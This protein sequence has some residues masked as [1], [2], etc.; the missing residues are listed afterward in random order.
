[1]ERIAEQSTFPKMDTCDVSH[2]IKNGEK[3]VKNVKVPLCW[4]AS[5]WRSLLERFYHHQMYFP[6]PF[7]PLGGFPPTSG[8]AIAV[9]VRLPCSAV[10][11]PLLS[12]P[13]PL[14]PAPRPRASFV[15][16]GGFA[17]GL[18]GVT[19]GTLLPFCTLLGQHLNGS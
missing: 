4:R 7:L 16:G 18:A 17:M 15:G 10:P 2:K 11:A 14:S 13:P 1:M 6:K 3:D 19:F 5:K 12:P 9:F 8:V